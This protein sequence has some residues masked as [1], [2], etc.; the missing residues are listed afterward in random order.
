MSPK[1][2]WSSSII[3]KAKSITGKRARIV[4]DHI[5]RH[6]TITT[7]EL[8]ELYGYDHPPRAIKDVT[9]QGLPLEREM[10]TNSSGKKMARYTF[11]DPSTIRNDRH[12][13]RTVIPIAFKEKLVEAYGCRCNI[14]SAQ[15]EKRYLQ[16]D[17]R[18]PYEIAADPSLDDPHAFMPLC[19][20]CNRAKSWSCEHCDNRLTA[21]DASVCETCYWAVPEKYTHIAGTPSRRLDIQWTGHEVPEFDGLA[22]Q[23]RSLRVALPEFVKKAL[24]RFM[25]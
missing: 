4:V 16:V 5:L 6:G 20:S 7:E 9:D 18:I 13:G 24:R 19:G 21:K 11:G 8:K 2:S 10:I 23:A 22:K 3:E 1:P 12:G 25:E 15:L 14:C 17:H